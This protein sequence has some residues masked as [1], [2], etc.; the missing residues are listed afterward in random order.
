MH[1]GVHAGRVGGMA[2]TNDGTSVLFFSFWIVSPVPHL[3][4]NLEA[5]LTFFISLAFVRSPLPLDVFGFPICTQVSHP[6]PILGFRRPQTGSVSSGS[7]TT[8]SESLLDVGPLRDQP[9]VPN[10]KHICA[11]TQLYFCA[12]VRLCLSTHVRLRTCTAVH[13]RACRVVLVHAWTAYTEQ[14]QRDF[15]WAWECEW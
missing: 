5:Q 15:K 8:N 11:H 13:V 4:I 9:S 7:P 12:Y 6:L 2:H 1:L 14:E 3:R 10:I